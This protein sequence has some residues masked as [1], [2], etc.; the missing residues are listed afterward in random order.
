[1]GSPA[2]LGAIALAVAFAAALCVALAAGASGASI[3]LRFPDDRLRTSPVQA[4]EVPST[5]SRWTPRR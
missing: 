5:A 3:H 4:C 1:M 2:R